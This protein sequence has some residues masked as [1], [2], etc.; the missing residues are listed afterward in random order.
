MKSIAAFEY[1]KIS[2]AYICETAVVSYLLFER[3]R[4]CIQLWRS[5]KTQRCF[6]LFLSVTIG[7]SKGEW[8][9]M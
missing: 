4:K 9:I 5:W 7:V 3:T 2:G 1:G 6:I 8:E